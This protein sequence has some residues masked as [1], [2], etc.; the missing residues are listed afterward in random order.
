MTLKE[1]RKKINLTQEECASYLGIPLRTYQNY[2]K[3]DANTQSIK[4][5]FILEKLQQ[6]ALVDEEHGLLSVEE[7]KEICEPVFRE[8]GIKY[9]Y[10]FG[11]YAKGGALPTSDV[12]ILVSTDLSGIRFYE[13]VEALREGLKKKVDVLNQDQIKDN[14]QLVNE[15]LQDGVKIYG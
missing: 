5:R 14:F 15:I 1:L 10:L 9:S 12:D 8:Y 13:M 3:P 4:Y 2:E 11:S 6:Y 7:I